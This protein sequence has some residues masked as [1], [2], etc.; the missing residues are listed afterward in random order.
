MNYKPRFYHIALLLCLLFASNNLLSYNPQQKIDSLLR[1]SESAEGLEK[2]KI[3]VELSQNYRKIDI[4]KTIEYGL[5]AIEMAK[6]AQNEKL[7]CDAMLAVSAGYQI[8]GK[9]QEAT[10]L[11]EK[12][13]SVAK[14]NNLDRE[15]LYCYNYLG[16]IYYFI[17]NLEVSLKYYRKV[18]DYIEQHNLVDSTR[19]QSLYYS[20]LSNLSNIY[21][22]KEQYEESLAFQQKLLLTLEK[23]PQTAKGDIKL[24]LLNNIGSNY[25][26]L[27]E[28]NRAKYYVEN[29]L[30]EGLKK[31]DS[32]GLIPVYQN[33]GEIALK[34]GENEK[35][36]DFYQTALIYAENSGNLRSLALVKSSVINYYE[37]IEDYKTA[38]LTQKDFLELQDSIYNLD[39]ITQL[40][41]MEVKY[42][43]V[44]KEQEI[45]LQK[46]VISKQKWIIGI[47]TVALLII[48]CLGVLVFN[49][50]QEKSV[51]YELL[52]KRQLEIVKEQKKLLP[53]SKF[54]TE[55]TLQVEFTEEN[56]EK[57]ESK[58][59]SS[60]PSQDQNFNELLILMQEKKPFLQGDLTLDKLSKL[61]N[62]NRTYL[63]QT[64]KENCSSSFNDF[65]NE[66]RV[67]E[68][69]RMLSE[70]E[71]EHLS[72]EGIA[73][74][75]G[76]NSK[77]TFNKAFKQ[78]TGITPSY[79]KNSISNIAHLI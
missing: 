49:Q 4:D 55:N 48:V 18:D 3:Y 34:L 31:N 66:Y 54:I 33:M 26:R 56:K 6:N 58:I 65:V 62:T 68:A 77:S 44:K 38:F 76:F 24:N 64:I 7:Q 35:A 22:L 71:F 32:T 29:A 42:E 73:H 47:G 27:G 16:N 36:H 37:N 40:S 17:S 61:L 74:S 45:A 30:K 78:F 69:R 46:S 70:K 25:K 79:F 72:I 52:V 14:N 39:F 28:Y 19:Y 9:Y 11:L 20:N 53:N 63:S 43:T 51:A 23:N 5:E 41:E 67:N 10:K 75:V 21:T 12:C 2:V 1:A 15:V 8:K 57:L 50:F 13:L 59:T 60:T